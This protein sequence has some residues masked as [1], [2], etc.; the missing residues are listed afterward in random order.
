MFAFRP[1]WSS[2]HSQSTMSWISPEESLGVRPSHR[3]EGTTE[4][5]INRITE[6]CQNLQLQTLRL[7]TRSRDLVVV[8]A[9]LLCPHHH[10]LYAATSREKHGQP[11]LP[12]QSPQDT[13]K[14]TS[15]TT[16]LTQQTH[17]TVTY[18]HATAGAT[19]K[20]ARAGRAAQTARMKCRH[21]LRH[22]GTHSH[23]RRDYLKPV[24]TRIG[25]TVR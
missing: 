24:T 17:P 5:S 23:N 6:Q 9:H 14:G 22:S 11:R 21:L 15:G 18:R 1:L 7:R 19:D 16:R 4:T 2:I 8:P 25:P 10:S 13:K 3:I 20:S 12:V